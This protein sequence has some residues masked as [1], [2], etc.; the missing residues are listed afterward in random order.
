M[1]HILVAL[2]PNPNQLS[3]SSIAGP[4]CACGLGDAITLSMTLHH[5]W[6]LCFLS[7]ACTALTPEMALF[8]AAWEQRRTTCYSGKSCHITTLKTATLLQGAM[9][10]PSPRL[11]K[12]LLSNVDVAMLMWCMPHYVVGGAVMEASARERNIC[13]LTLG[14]YCGCIGAGNS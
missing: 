2:Q 12:P 7:C 11:A 10:P 9:Y 1:C 8:G 13:S 14:L 6:C 4:S 5:P 3:N